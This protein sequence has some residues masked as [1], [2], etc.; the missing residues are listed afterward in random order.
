M[1]T[2]GDFF[3]AH[4]HSHL[5]NYVLPGLTS[6]LLHC[7]PRLFV[8]SRNTLDGQITP[9]SH[10]FDF[11]CLVL[12]GGVR[13]TK[14]KIATD[15]GADL[16]S[17]TTLLYEGAPGNYTMHPGG[18]GLYRPFVGSFGP[19]EWYGMTHDEIHSIEFAK[20]TEVLFFEG[21]NVTDQT[22]ILEPCVDGARIPTF[23]VKPWMFEKVGA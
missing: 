3:K 6:M 7:T 14:W 5:A 19:G 21:P 11:I 15:R 4:S 10:R 22:I 12:K 8:S 18:N 13:N 23:E 16:F 20:D 17:R 1:S 2:P 9:H